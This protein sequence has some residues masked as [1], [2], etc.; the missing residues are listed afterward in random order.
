[1]DI[2]SQLFV[3]IRL[4]FFYDLRSSVT[5]IFALLLFYFLNKL[6]HDDGKKIKITL[7]YLTCCSMSFAVLAILM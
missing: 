4:N 1:M 5:S 2:L 3:F 7:K 6:L